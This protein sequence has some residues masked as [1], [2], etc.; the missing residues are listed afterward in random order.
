MALTR[1]A[2]LEQIG[3]LGG[4][5]AAYMAME[6][7]AL[8]APTPA[9][10]ENFALPAQGGSGRSVVILGAGVAGLLF[11]DRAQESRLRGHGPG[12]PRAS[13]RAGVDDPR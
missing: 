3:R 9:G 5:G 8:A 13:W 11:R 12:G 7:L 10:A 2:L 6:T 4:S 1:R